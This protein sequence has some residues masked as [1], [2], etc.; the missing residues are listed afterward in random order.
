MDGDLYE[1]AFHFDPDDPIYQDHFP[2]NPVVP[3]SLIIHAFVTAASGMDWDVMPK[4][5]RNFRFKRFVP[6]GRYAYR[7]RRKDDGCIACMLLDEQTT[8]VTGSIET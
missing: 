8:V 3:G 6:P 4:G 7:M 2:G 5:I 1:G